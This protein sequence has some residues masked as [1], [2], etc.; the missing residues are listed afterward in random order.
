VSLNGNRTGVWVLAAPLLLMGLAGAATLDG[1]QSAGTFVATGGMKTPRANHT[2]TLL[3]NG[4]V[5]ITGGTA[6]YGN[7]LAS[8][9]LYDP[10][11]KE[12][13]TAA[14][15]TSPRMAHTATLLPDGRVLVTGGT[16]GPGAGMVGSSSAEIYDASTGTFT[17]AAN[18]I[19]KHVCHQ[20]HLLADG[21]VMLVGGVDGAGGVSKAELYDPHAGAF[22]AAE[23]S[24]SWGNTCQAS[25]SALLPDSR[26]LIIAEDSGVAGI[27]DAVSGS[28][29][30]A[31]YPPLDA[32]AFN[33]GLPSA[34]LLMSGRVLVAGG[35]HDGGLIALAG[36]YA[37]DGGFA[38]AG[39]MTM[40]RALHSATL[41]P[42]GSV[43]MAGTYLYGGASL[44]SAELYAPVADAFTAAG[45]M[46]T[47]RANHTA[48]LLNNGRVLIAGGSAGGIPHASA[49]LYTP[50]VLIRAPRLSFADE[51]GRGAIWHA[52]TVEM[53][54]PRSP[55]VAGEVLSMYTRRLVEGSV[56]PPQVA[57][58]GRLAGIVYFGDAPGYPGYSQVNFRVPNGVSTGSAVPVRL[59]Y[60]GRPSDE[61]SL[62][63]R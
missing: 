26:V 17:P 60:I 53:V 63:V 16:T 59:T 3:T 43:L 24:V 9:E 4:K 5:L 37:S 42:D 29:A 8:S 21:R 62:A 31:D 44:A 12:F 49:E 34:T 23:L 30:S 1:A 15:M 61:V 32:W 2:A 45:S 14:D 54:S 52:S 38:P 39:R 41:L 18:M 48:T 22:A 46:S 55:A 19:G 20:A 13:T 11:R 33:N 25:A 6:D 27:Y 47:A 35:G 57:V 58:G 51:T 7:P 40:G 36:L 10:Q 50:H 56:I 28:F